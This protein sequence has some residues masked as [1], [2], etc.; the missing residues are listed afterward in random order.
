MG[1]QYRHGDVFVERVA[2]TISAAAT[3]R[4]TGIVAY[5]EATG[6]AHRVVGGTV[7]EEPGG[8]LWIAAETATTLT[9]EEHGVIPLPAGIYRVTQ[10][11][12]WDPYAEAARRVID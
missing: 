4:A 7:Y 3:V 9:H 11:R 2:G 12:E 1:Q 10:Q 6:H 8:S 5:G